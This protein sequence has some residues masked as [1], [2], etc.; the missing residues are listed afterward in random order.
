MKLFLLKNKF[1][2]DLLVSKNVRVQ[3]LSV[4]WPSSLGRFKIWN[5]FGLIFSPVKWEPGC[6]PFLT[7]G[8]GWG[9]GVISK[10]KRNVRFAKFETETAH[11]HPQSSW[12]TQLQGHSSSNRTDPDVQARTFGEAGRSL[13]FIN[14]AHTQRR[15][16]KKVGQEAAFSTREE[17]VRIHPFALMPELRLPHPATLSRTLTLSES[18]GGICPYFIKD[19]WKHFSNWR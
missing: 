18:P 3:W 13:T 16:K 4:L 6:L 14:W 2:K 12:S 1:A 7:Q 11:S 19:L 17:T 9:V 10:T 5:N 15:K 8:G